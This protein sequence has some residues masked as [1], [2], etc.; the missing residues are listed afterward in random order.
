M[1]GLASAG[2]EAMMAHS[3]STLR[4]LDVHSCRHISR[5][6][7]ENVFAENKVYPEL[8]E[9]NISFCQGVNDFVCGL[10][11]RTCPNLKT[12]KVFGNFGVKDVRVPKGK[13][14][15]G[16]PNALGMQIEGTELAEDEGRVI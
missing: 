15:I 6:A 4:Y 16:V 11:F 10:I 3:G 2:F 8:R 1:I 14:L 12:L 7:F 9:L 13:I 5:E